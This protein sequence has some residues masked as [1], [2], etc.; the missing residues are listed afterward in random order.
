[1]DED[2]RRILIIKSVPML[3]E[4]MMAAFNAIVVISEFPIFVVGKGSINE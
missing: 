1:M 4:P 2:R 3:P